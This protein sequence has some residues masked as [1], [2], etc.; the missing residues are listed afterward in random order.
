VAQ[1]K[2]K[3]DKGETAG[4]MAG[5]KGVADRR[6]G[7]NRVKESYVRLCAM[8]DPQIPGCID[9]GELF[10]KTDEQGTG[11][12]GNKEINK[13]FPE[14]LQALVEKSHDHGN[15]PCQGRDFDKPLSAGMDDGVKKPVVLEQPV[16]TL[17]VI[18]MGNPPQIQSAVFKYGSQKNENQREEGKQ[19][20]VVGGICFFHEQRKRVISHVLL[21]IKK[22]RFCL[23]DADGEAITEFLAGRQITHT[24]VTTWNLLVEIQQRHQREE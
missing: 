13:D 9:M 22:N 11:G 10:K 2:I 18:E 14:R 16:L 23:P 15:E 8:K 24:L 20:K 17:K 5:G 12:C 7:G 3:A 19:K 1:E 4:G 6:A 21:P